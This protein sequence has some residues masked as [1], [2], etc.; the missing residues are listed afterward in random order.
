MDNLVKNWLQGLKVGN[1][2]VPKLGNYAGRQV[3]IYNQTVTYCLVSYTDDGCGIFSV[4]LK[5]LKL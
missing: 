5:D 1:K 3:Y 2:A 4:D